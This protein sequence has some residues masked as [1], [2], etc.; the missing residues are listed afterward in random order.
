[1]AAWRAGRPPALAPGTIV[2]VHVKQ[3][4]IFAKFWQ[5]G[6]VKTRLAERIGAEQACRLHRAFVRTVVRR[7]EHLGD[8]RV[9]AFWPPEHRSAF[10]ELAGPSWQLEPQSGPDLGE[11]MR[12]YFQSAVARGA[13]EVILLGSDSPTLPLATITVA[14]EQLRS[15]AVVLGP[16][17]DGG[18]Y[19]VGASRAVPPIFNNVAWSSSK[20]WEQTTQHLDDSGVGWHKLP[21][22]YDVDRLMDLE[23]LGDELRMAPDGDPWLPELRAAVQSA[24]T[25]RHSPHV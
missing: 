15:H 9:L 22:W 4:G 11:R 20:V 16:A 7:M 17:E 25:K 3:L 12:N 14:F 6:Q 10:A 19:L 8:V 18:Y 1:M 2:G 5:A 13:S 23:R 24:L 21:T